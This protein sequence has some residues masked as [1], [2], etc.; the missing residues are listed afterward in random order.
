MFVNNFI[1]PN[2]TDSTDR[3]GRNQ[4]IFSYLLKYRIIYL[5]G[6]IE[7]KVAS[8][9]NATLMVLNAEDSQKP[10]LLYIH[11]PGGDLYAGLSIVDCILN[12]SAPVHTICIFAASAGALILSVGEVIY[13]YK[14]STIMLHQPHGGARG[15]TTDLEIQVKEMN[16]K[17]EI[18]S[19]IIFQ[20]IAKRQKITMSYDTF[21]QKLER[22]WYLSGEEALEL[23]L[24]DNILPSKM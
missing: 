12:I 1:I 4:D 23:G 17:K 9:I 22:D 21:K 7:E 15:Q 11:S 8:I 18:A 3:Y 19:H 10:I 5:S 6:E 13:A 2:I 20:S 16:S 14:R 24:I